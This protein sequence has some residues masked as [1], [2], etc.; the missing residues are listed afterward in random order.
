MPLAS[1]NKF[2]VGAQDGKGVSLNDSR[3]QGEYTAAV[4]G[5]GSQSHHGNN[6]EPSHA[7]KT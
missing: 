5:V 4:A 2:R 3:A 1:K 6:Y 7:I